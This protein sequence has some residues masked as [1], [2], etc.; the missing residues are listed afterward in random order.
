[1]NI[2]ANDDKVQ[3]EIRQGVLD[4]LSE[5]FGVAPDKFPG[6]DAGHFWGAAGPLDVVDMVY[7][8]HFLEGKHGIQFTEADYDNPDFY[9]LDGLVGAIMQK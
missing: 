6:G 2:C 9:T 7:L 4:L 5:R 8:V 1:M 3:N